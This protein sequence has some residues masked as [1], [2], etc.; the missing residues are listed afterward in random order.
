MEKAKENTGSYYT[1]GKLKSMDCVST[2]RSCIRISILARAHDAIK[3][4]STMDALP[5]VVNACAVYGKR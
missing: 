3:C 5:F 4:A 1:F 2:F